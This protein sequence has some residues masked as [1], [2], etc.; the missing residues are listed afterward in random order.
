MHASVIVKIYS[1]DVFEFNRERFRVLD[2]FGTE[3]MYND[4]EYIQLHPAL[5]SKTGW[6]GFGLHPRQFYT[7]YREHASVFFLNED[8]L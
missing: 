6:G 8:H 4:P 3:P 7:L 1:S 5:K 2:A